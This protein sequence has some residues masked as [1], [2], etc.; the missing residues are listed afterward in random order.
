MIV[1]SFLEY[2]RQKILQEAL[3]K[4]KKKKKWDMTDSSN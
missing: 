4:K 1:A 2:L 3:D